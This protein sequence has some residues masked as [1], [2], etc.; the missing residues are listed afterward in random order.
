MI[1]IILFIS[2]IILQLAY[3]KI[4]DKYDIIDKPNQRSS[5]NRVT[6]RGG[7]IIFYIGALLYFLLTGFEYPW[8]FAGLTVIAGISFA[9]DITPLPPRLRLVIHLAAISLMLYELSFFSVPWYYTA[10]AAI[11]C[12][13]IINVYNFMDGING[14][15]VGY[16]LVTAGALWYANNYIT[17][18]TDNGLIYALILSFAV[19]G[20]FNFRNKAKCFAGDIG[21]VSAAFLIVFLL[22][23]L[24]ITTRDIS[25]LTLLAVYG[26]DG[27]LTIIHRIMLRE[28]ISQPHRKHAY[29]ILANEL[30]IPHVAV[31]LIYM[32]LQTAVS[33][34]LFIFHDHR[35]IY[36]AAVI[37]AL[38][39]IY[40][41]LMKKYFH[42]H[43]QRAGK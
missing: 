34:G 20:I 32:V 7:G 12:V 23:G 6:I 1:Y 18:F 24:I 16:S 28:N 27:G 11:L 40:V 41:I 2:L 38:S 31:S 26:V 13:G 25:Y 4:A 33:A 19:F 22:G 5:H 15:T 43:T 42:L 36:M 17:V 29:Q 3:F 8:F 35:Y 30:A 21:S 39:V 37:A 10:A 9:D 14:L